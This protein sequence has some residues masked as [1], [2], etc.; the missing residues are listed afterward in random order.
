MPPSQIL[1][2]GSAVCRLCPSYGGARRG[3]PRRRACGDAGRGGAASGSSA[4]AGGG[5]MAARGDACRGVAAARGEAE[6]RAASWH[7]GKAPGG[8]K[9][10][11]VE[12]PRQ[13]H[14]RLYRALPPAVPAV[15]AL[16]RAG[17]DGAPCRRAARQRP[18]HEAAA[19]RCRASRA[20][21]V[22][23]TGGTCSAR[24]RDGRCG[25]GC[26]KKV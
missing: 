20:A 2:G 14:R 22:I 19:M 23:A 12:L 3:R 26:R 5:G 1:H 8:G 11:Q 18:S 6:A 4:L 15:R 17:R 21:A 7:S 16:P 24:G 13:Q 10:G 25:I 9:G